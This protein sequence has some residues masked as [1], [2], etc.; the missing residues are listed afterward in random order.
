MPAMTEV[1][2]LATLPRD[3]LTDLRTVHATIGAEELQASREFTDAGDI[4]NA[5]IRFER[6]YQAIGTVELI[7]SVLVR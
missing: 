6:A 1:E 7:D 2:Q 3:I 4:R 5:V